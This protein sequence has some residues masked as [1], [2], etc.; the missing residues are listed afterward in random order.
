IEVRVHH[1]V[2]RIDAAGREIAARDLHSGRSYSEPYTSLVLAPGASPVRPEIPGIDSPGVFSVRNVPDSRA[3]RG[4]ISTRSPKRA[5]VVGASYLGLEMAENL[6]RRGLSVTVVDL[7]AQVMPVLDPEM[8]EPVSRHL[9]THRV[10]LHLGDGMTA[11]ERSGSGGLVLL[12]SAG[13]R[14]PADMIVLSL[15]AKPEVQLA[16]DAGIDIGRLGGIRVDDSMRTSTPGIWAVGDAVEVRNIVTGRPCL[17]PLAGP[18]N[19][20]GRVAADSICGR[21]T[22]FPGVAGTSVCGIFG[23]TVAATGASEKALIAAGIR[24]YQSVFLHPMQHASYYPGAR[25]LHM[26]LVFSVPEGR[27]LGAQAVGEEGADKRID[28]IAMAVQRGAT[29]FDLEEAELCYAP[30][31]GTA[32]DPVNMAGMI[33]ANVLRGDLLL[34]RWQDLEGTAAVLVDVRDP[35]EF[36]AGHIDGAMNIPLGEFRQRLTSLPRHKEIWVHCAIGQRA[37]YAAR[38]LSQE[39]FTARLLPGGYETYWGYFP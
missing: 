15:G 16:R 18:A 35:H 22:R 21:D 34:A 11:I 32:K 6:A 10:D 13:A 9:E 28:V 38:I 7:L 24:Q 20:Q 5:V 25:R 33:A 30:Q 37:Y 1:E 3:I 12:T 2:T 8:A 4:W 36:A 26:K 27:I 39:G 14:L 19:R 23:L 29:V 31:Y 17:L